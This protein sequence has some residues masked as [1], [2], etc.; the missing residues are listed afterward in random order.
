MKLQ[1]TIFARTNLITRFVIILEY[2]CILI[3]K[4]TLDKITQYKQYLLLSRVSN[5]FSKF[6]LKLQ[7]STNLITKFVIILEYFCTIVLKKNLDKIT[8]Y[9]NI[10]KIT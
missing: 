4:K 1:I 7:R 10:L 8:Q 5:V 6:N 2:F 9:I 3:L